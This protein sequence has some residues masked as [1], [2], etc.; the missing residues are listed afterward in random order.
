M[1]VII[2]DK[3]DKGYLLNRLFQKF[4]KKVVKSNN[5]DFESVMGFCT[6]KIIKLPFKVP[7]FVKRKCNI[8][9]IDLSE[10]KSY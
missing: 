7:A 8:K 2:G 9:E 4:G 6:N 5:K 3:E 10:M 1:R